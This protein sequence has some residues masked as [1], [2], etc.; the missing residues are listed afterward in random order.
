MTGH[1]RS[2]KCTFLSMQTPPTDIPQVYTPL[3][4]KVN[5]L[6]LQELTLP[7]ATVSGRAGT[8]LPLAI[9]YPMPRDIGIIRD[10]S[11]RITDDAGRASPHNSCN[12]AIGGDSAG[13]NL[14]NN[15]VDPLVEWDVFNKI[16][17][18]IFGHGREFPFDVT[19][20]L[21][22]AGQRFAA[23]SPLDPCQCLPSPCMT[24]KLQ[25][26][27]TS[28]DEKPLLEAPVIST[29]RDPGLGIKITNHRLW[30]NC[31]SYQSPPNGRVSE[32]CKL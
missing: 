14:T 10:S 3:S 15:G 24:V 4:V 1:E 5:P 22:P 19:I 8:D 7:D 2:V 27:K 21:P 6:C 30:G 25:D 9:D 23:L 11:H 32:V 12:L 20:A 16:S 28:P 13:R 31:A 17:R 18:E 26:S 29:T